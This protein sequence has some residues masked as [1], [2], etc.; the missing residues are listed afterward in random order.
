MLP[1]LSRRQLLQAI[2]AGVAVVPVLEA[3]AVAAPRPGLP[4]G[5]DLPGPA[6]VRATMEAWSDIIVPGERRTPDDRAV[7]GATAGPGAVQAG[8]WTLL[9]DPSVGIGPAL[10]ALAGLLNAAAVDQ[11]RRAKLMLDP[12]VPPLVA[13]PF[14]QRTDLA[15]RLLGGSGPQQVVWYALAAIALLAFHTAG[16]LDTADA[17]RRGHPGLAWLRFPQP[18]A[19][20][21]WR[22][23][24][25][26]YGR[27]LARRHPRTTRMGHPA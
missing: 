16:H 27:A 25:F 21:L 13:L 5:P 26:S 22:Y 3:G 23:D 1:A 2:A 4:S 15:V 14:D 24:D 20:D 19:D 10:P 11:A 12:T 8:A 6:S 17:V 18:G 7:A 9:N